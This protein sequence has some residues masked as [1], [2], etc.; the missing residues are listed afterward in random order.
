MRN[1]AIESLGKRRKKSP[2]LKSGEL[3]RNSCNMIKQNQ[4]ISGKEALDKE[5]ER[6]SEKVFYIFDGYRALGDD[7]YQFRDVY[8]PTVTCVC[9]DNHETILGEDFSRR[10]CMKE[11]K[12]T[13]MLD[14]MGAQ[15]CPNGVVT[16][17][18]DLKDHSHYREYPIGQCAEQHA[19]NE[20]LKG[21][22]CRKDIKND[23]LFGK[24]I[25]CL[26]GEDWDYCQNCRDLFNI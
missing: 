23:I 18:K 3:G 20:L 12:E 13:Q 8:Y 16:T 26:T 17:W 24:P 25:R 22:G 5:S 10:P 4:G 14:E 2:A 19:A 15:F 7:G 6:F 21:L 1:S 11:Y 9:T